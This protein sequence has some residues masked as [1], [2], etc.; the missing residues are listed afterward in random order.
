[1]SCPV[2]I[3]EASFAAKRNFGFTLIEL[4]VV[5]AIIGILASLLLPALARAK[6]KARSI[7]CLSNV[8]QI[9]LSYKIALADDPSSDRLDKESVGNW[10]LDTVG[11]PQQ[12]WICPSAPVKAGR[13]TNSLGWL[14][15]AWIFPGFWQN[16][17]VWL[18][19]PVDKVVSPPDVRTG[20]YGLNFWLFW[21]SR[22]F[23]KEGRS[24]L[25]L[26]KYR[27]E[28]ESRIQNPA[29]TPLLTD[30]TQYQELPIEIGG[31]PPTWVYGS[32]PFEGLTEM[33]FAAIARH[34]NRPNRIPK[35]WPVGQL[36]PGAVNAG[37]FD[38]H[39]EQVRLERLW[40]L[41]WHH[42]WQAPPKP[43]G[44]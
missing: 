37:F 39:A 34:G 38:G 5:I 31:T 1:M 18:D 23:N 9:T 24:A 6:D 29:F 4:L 30:A 35:R 7:K 32:Q 42:G 19:V 3:A 17:A 44:L 13:E 22:N 28:T 11:V 36:L 21:T 20:S 33:G 10:F 43:P 41:E 2:Q 27:F 25:T 14:D 15:S 12:G 8:R 40:Q 26:P 16:R